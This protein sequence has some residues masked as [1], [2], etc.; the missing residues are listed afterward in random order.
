LKAEG[1]GVD[2]VKMR[3]Q[4][5]RLVA[6]QWSGNFDDKGNEIEN[7]KEAGFDKEEFDKL[8]VWMDRDI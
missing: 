6:F 3:V 1:D 4:Y 5:D 7:T 8:S 2:L